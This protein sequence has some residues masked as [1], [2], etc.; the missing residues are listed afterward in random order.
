[1]NVE[2]QKMKFESPE[3]FET[4]KTNKVEMESAKNGNEE[5]KS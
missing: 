1:M 3:N 5:R 2:N 4:P